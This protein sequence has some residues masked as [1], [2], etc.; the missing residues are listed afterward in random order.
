MELLVR[1]FSDRSVGL[2]IVPPGGSV[3]D[4]T[5]AGS[6]ATIAD[7]VG[8]A[9]RQPA[10]PQRITARAARA[11]KAAGSPGRMGAPASMRGPRWG[12]HGSASG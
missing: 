12:V 8:A 4:E 5:F 10:P 2:D 11:L 3:Q 6:W 9:G 1:L 7:P